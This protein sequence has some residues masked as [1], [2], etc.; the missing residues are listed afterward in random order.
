[1]AITSFDHSY[2]FLSN[3]YTL[4]E[5]VEYK[6]CEF[7]SVEAAYQASKTADKTV[8]AMFCVLTPKEAKI[9][10][11]NIIMRPD[12]ESE[13]LSIMEDLVR[14]KFTKSERLKQRL[15]ETGDEELIEGNNW[16]DRFWGVDGTGEN[17]LGKILMKIRSELRT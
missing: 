4:T 1:M 10:G 12:F 9:L 7:E 17:H 11:R 5:P 15:L 3:F 6:Y 8:R 2:R 13:K 14:Q 16:G